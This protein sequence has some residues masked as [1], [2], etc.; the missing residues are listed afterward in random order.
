[1][2]NLLFLIKPYVPWR[3]EYPLIDC[4]KQIHLTILYTRNIFGRICNICVAHY[5]VIHMWKY[6][7]YE[8]SVTYYTLIMLC[9]FEQGWV[10]GGMYRE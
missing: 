9:L 6:I 10:A 2:W 5:W 8:L 4:N 1:M 7:Q 3:K